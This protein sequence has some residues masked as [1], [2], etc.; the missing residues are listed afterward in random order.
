MTKKQEHPLVIIFHPLPDGWL[1]LLE[2]RYHTIIAPQETRGLTRVLDD[3]LEGASA[4]FTL[5]T[6]PIDDAL[7]D[8]APNLKVVSNMAVGVDN[9]DLT[10]CTRRGIPV[11]HTPGV[12]T[13]GT[14]DL[15]MAILLSTARKLNE[16]SVD[17]KDG[18]WKTWSPT[19]WLGLD[20]FNRTMGIVGMGKIGQAVAKRAHGFG[21]KIMYTDTSPKPGVETQFNAKRVPLENLL[22]VSDFV[23]LHVPLTDSTHGLMGQVVNTD[24]LVEALSK[25]RI[26]AAALD[27][28]D[29]EPLPPNHPLY[30]LDNCLITPHIGSAT[31]GTRKSMAELACK[32]II[33][34]LESKPLYHCANPKVYENT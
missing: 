31:F 32:N 19:G 14:A 13:E 24:D 11:G 27:V 17:A 16:A 7:L 3:H 15:T 6:D 23:C 26:Y 4:I 20:L 34:G 1:S 2:T 33:S 25:R 28:T 29:P 22:G 21:M 8:R 9:I 5:L 12:L 18:Q 10:A 30:H